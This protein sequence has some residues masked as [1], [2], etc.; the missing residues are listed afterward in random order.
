MT[1]QI[2]IGTRASPLALVQTQKVS[3]ALQA[4]HG[5]SDGV[6]QAHKIVT[7]GDSIQDKPLA[8]IGGKGLFTQELDDGL[9]NKT[10]D[11]AVHSLKDMP[12][13]DEPGLVIGA[14]LLREDARDVLVPRAGL[15][16]GADCVSDLPQGAKI[17]TASLRRRAQLLHL[18][19]DLV[20]TNLRGSV[21]TRLQKIKD[22]GLDGTILAMA[23]LKRLGLTPDGA[24]PIDPQVMLP[25]AGQG[26][27][28]VQCREDDEEMHAWLQAVHCA[29]T[30]AV[31]TAERK[32]LNALDG[33]CRTPIAAYG[34]LSQGRL[35]LMGR[36]LS[37]E[38]DDCAAG[39]ITG[40]ASDA[41]A[42]GLELAAQLKADKPHLVRSN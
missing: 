16:L 41:A 31:V 38:G 13:E 19:P 27:L 42:L 40:L 39:Q 28:A 20:I 2:H 29:D 3:T 5:W 21:G 10:L 25:A 34:Q 14:L 23:G 8:D 18:R 33:S 36:L 35:T 4:A 17:G 1:R 22:T 26:A 24:M 11:L 7:R 37:D 12:T 6:V 32:F 15:E 9:R 30:E